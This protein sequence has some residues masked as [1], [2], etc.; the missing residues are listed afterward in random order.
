VGRKAFAAICAASLTFEERYCN[1]E[2][3]R[4]ASHNLMGSQ[5]RVVEVTLESNLK[6]VEIAEEINRRIC[7]T[8]GCGE[9]EEFQVGMA[10]HEA[11]INA[12][13]HGNKNDPSKRVWLQFRFFPERLEIHVRD[14]GQGFDVEKVP[15][16]VLD[17]NLLSVSGRGIFL[18][19]KFMDEVR[20]EQ[21]KSG[22]TEIIMVKRLNPNGQTHQGG[23]QR[24]HEGDSKAS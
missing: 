2:S 8:A 22:G 23:S 17:S 12:I 10:L 5:E 13:W 20:V 14:E 11:V 3:G 21:P 16:P 4:V 19:R 24:E 18:I 7:M 6:N 1:F 15:D 9:E